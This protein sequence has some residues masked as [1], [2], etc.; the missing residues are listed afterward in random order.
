MIKAIILSFCFIGGCAT[1]TGAVQ[2]FTQSVAA[3]A[4][5]ND[6]V[7]TTATKLLNAGSITSKQAIKVLTVTDG[8]N[9]TLSKANDAYNAGSATN[10]NQLVAS[11]M[12]ALNLMQSCLAVPKGQVDSCLAPISVGVP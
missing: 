6:A 11:V 8:V 7:V 9:I 3:A 4:A 2:T 5:A 10:A 12:S 1:Q